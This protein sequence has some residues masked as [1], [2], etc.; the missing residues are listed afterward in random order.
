[1]RATIDPKL[2]GELSRLK[3]LRLGKISERPRML[4]SLAAIQT[5]VQRRTQVK[6]ETILVD[7][8][9][10]E[11]NASPLPVMWDKLEEPGTF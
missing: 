8:V 7:E 3:D 2:S 4:H 9:L 1:M 6:T 11:P 10:E 5:S